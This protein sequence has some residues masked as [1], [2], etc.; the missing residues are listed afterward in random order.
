MRLWSHLRYLVLR[1][2]KSLAGRRLQR[3]APEVLERAWR[4]R[5]DR[6]ARTH[7]LPGP[8]QIN[9]TSYPSR[10]GLLDRTV[11]S[12]LLQDMTPDSVVL[13][14]HEADAARLP[15]SVLRLQ[16]E[17][18]LVVRTVPRDLGSYK[19]LLPAVRE[20]PDAWHVTAD[21]DIYYPP[22][23]LGTLANGF[24]GDS[25]EILCCRAHYVTLHRDGSLRPYRGWH[26][27]TEVRGPDPRLF[28]TSGAGVLFPP[29]SLDPRVTDAE[30]A[31]ALA[32]TA[33]DLWWYWMA[34]L[35]GSTVRRV[36]DNRRLITWE[37]AREHSL[38]HRNKRKRDGL[39]RPVAPSRF[40]APITT[41]S[42]PR[43]H[44]TPPG[45][46]F[47]LTPPASPT[48]E[49]QEP[50]DPYLWLEEA[51]SAAA[52]EWA[53]VRT[54]RT[55]AGLQA[56]PVHDSIRA[57]LSRLIR[58]SVNP[59]NGLG[60][61]AV[62]GEYVD[63]YWRTRENPRAI[64]RRTTV[65][66]YLAGEP[67]WQT[68]LDLDSL[69][70]AEGIPWTI[71]GTFCLYPELRH[72]MVRLSRGGADVHE[73]REFDAERREFVSGGFSISDE[74]LHRMLWVDTN[75]VLVGTDFRSGRPNPRT[76][77]LWRRGTP[78]EDAK[79]LLEIAPSSFDV[80]FLELGGELL[81]R[82]RIDEGTERFH[83]LRGGEVVPLEL[84]PAQLGIVRGQL[85]VRPRAEW[86]VEKRTYPASAV[87][88]IDWEA[89]LA[90]SR[91]FTV[92]V[93][94][95]D[96]TV[97]DEIDI[98]KSSL[99]IRLLRNVR[100]ELHEYRF[101]DGRWSESTVPAPEFGIVAVRSAN[102]HSETYF[103]SHESALEAPTVYARRGGAVVP[104]FAVPNL[105][106]TSG[107]L[108]EQLEATSRDGTRVPYFVV[109]SRTM[110]FD[111]SNPTRM[112]GYGA[113]ANRSCRL[114]RP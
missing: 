56:L 50:P 31:L 108:I 109:R 60:N 57:E 99:V 41:S 82:E 81:I 55:I 38:W 78:L 40:P 5:G 53:R 4:T 97:V 47:R 110:T 36:G 102:P 23:W 15:E 67:Q 101:E 58:A 89:F 90:G 16:A 100:S 84:P 44:S 77:R 76:P 104:A 52:I 28:F 68:L 37:G 20:E 87:L 96:R 21:D 73:L 92:V 62:R 14:L 94:P 27:K 18:G 42:G 29:G 34:R 8:L 106:D 9:L 61:F 71:R 45:V 46:S 39:L 70:E 59:P 88:A 25:R 49:A 66:S 93:A 3:D 95:D 111:G 26:P 13:W 74:R 105:F 83:L 11:R 6:R 86:S 10:Y 103:F 24:R 98:T 54:E 48:L 69:A 85:M 79:P 22:D 12:L 19:K 114:M 65:E 7:P 2:W 17:A 112:F 91:D 35:A 43:S 80:S 63:D 72:C 113:T 64:W 32:P 75:T 1:K 51:E 33:D 30:L 107:F